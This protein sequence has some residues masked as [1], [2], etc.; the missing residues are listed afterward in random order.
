LSEILDLQTT[1]RVNQSIRSS[2]LKTRLLASYSS[3]DNLVCRHWRLCLCW[4]T[5]IVLVLLR[6]FIYFLLCTTRFM[7]N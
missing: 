5:L 1:K 3:V 7:V 4:Y 6:L 2:R